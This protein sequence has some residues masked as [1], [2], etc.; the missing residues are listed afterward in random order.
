MNNVLIIGGTASISNKIVEEF[1]NNLYSVDLMTYRQKEKINATH[2]WEYLDLNDYESVKL[3]LNKISGNKYKKIIL[4][5]ASSASYKN[6]A[7][8]DREDLVNFYGNFFVNYMI[9]VRELVKNLSEDGQIAYISSIAAN[10]PIDDVNYATGKGAMQTFIRSMSTK[11]KN[12]QAI[13]SVA[14]GLIYDTPAFYHNDPANYGGDISRL[15][16][17]EEIAQ[18]ILN[19]T[20]EKNGQIIKIGL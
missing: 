7:D 15:A 18:I 2:N 6:I 13:F 20:P 4:M 19:A 9:L 12:G 3:F 17:K 10:V 16:K 1:E 11:I 14:P 5:P 8:T